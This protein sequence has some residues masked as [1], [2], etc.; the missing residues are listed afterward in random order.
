[1][2]C[3]CTLAKRPRPVRP[4]RPQARLSA[5]RRGSTDFLHLYVGWGQAVASCVLCDPWSAHEA[6]RL[7]LVGDIFPVLKVDG[8]FV[9]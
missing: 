7:G 9:P 5:R 1:M 8:K 4:G 3:P 2:A 6:L